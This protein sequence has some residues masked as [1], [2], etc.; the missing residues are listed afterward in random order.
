MDVPQFNKII[1]DSRHAAAGAST[2][3]EISLP[4]TPPLPSHAFCYVCDGVI[5]NTMPTL[6]TGS[7]SLRHF[8]YWIERIGSVTAVNR[9]HLD[10][11]KMYNGII[12]ADEIQA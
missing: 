12:F 8:F 5:S 3:F 11:T 7:G 1:V 4:E 6:G 10:E 9:V 2:K